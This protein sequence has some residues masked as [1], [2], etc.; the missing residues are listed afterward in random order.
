MDSEHTPAP[1]ETENSNRIKPLWHLIFEEVCDWAETFT[2][3][4]A[5]L[6]IAFMFLFRYVTVDGESMTHTLEDKDRLIIVNT[7][8]NY[9]TGDI[10]VIRVPG[11]DQPLIKRVIATEGQTVEI[12]FETWIVTVDGVPLDEPYVRKDRDEL[13]HYWQFYNGPITVADGKMFVMGDNRNGSNDSRN[14]EIGQLDVSQA[15]G[16]VLIRFLPLDKFGTVD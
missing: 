12:D 3:A 14:P 4:L 13:L 15:L 10:V 11:R 7:Y 8:G 16:K 6:I 5:V 1:Q 9:K 2:L